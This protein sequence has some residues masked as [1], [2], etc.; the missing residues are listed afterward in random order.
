M[1]IQNILFLL[2]ILGG[3]YSC[4]SDEKLNGAITVNSEFNS[5]LQGWVGQFAN[6][7]QSVIDTNFKMVFKQTKLPFEIDSRKSGLLF[8]CINLEGN[9]FMFTKRK[10]WGLIPNATYKVTFDLNIGSNYSSETANTPG[11]DTY[12]KVG[13]TSIEPTVIL[14]NKVYAL[15]ID[16]GKLNESGVDMRV[17]GNITTPT[18]ENSYKIISKNNHADPISAVANEKGEIW[19]IV[20]ADCGYKGLTSLYISKIT[21]SIIF[22]KN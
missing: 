6:Y 13:A 4:K 18:T 22:E 17:L 3:I 8:G 7:S 5:G 20:G 11:P 15:N 19:L 14:T 12:I 1:K 16:K 10:M 9:M 2:V 21:T